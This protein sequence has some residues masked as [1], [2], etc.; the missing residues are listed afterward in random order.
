MSATFAFSFSAT[1]RSRMRSY[2]SVT[3]AAPVGVWYRLAEQGRVRVE[4]CVVQLAEHRDALVERLARDEPR[5][6]DALA[7]RLHETLEPGALRGVQE[8]RA[9]ERRDGCPDVAHAAPS[10]PRQFCDGSGGIAA[11]TR[12]GPPLRRSTALQRSSGS[13]VK[14]SSATAGS[15][16]H[17]PSS[18]SSSS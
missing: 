10:L 5:R 4:P 16:I 7:V 11:S 18:S 15:M 2:S 14:T 9:R 1:S 3:A 8:G 6:A 12:N 13:S 17:E